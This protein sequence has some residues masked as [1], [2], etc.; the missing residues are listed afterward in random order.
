MSITLRDEIETAINRQSAESGSN[1]PDFILA[2]YLTD[3]LAAFDKACNA[4]GRWYGTEIHDQKVLN[5][6]IADLP[7]LPGRDLTKCPSCGG[8]A[9]NGHDREF[10]PNV[11]ACTK[12]SAK[13]G[14][15]IAYND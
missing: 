3:C 1:T 9:D 8:P 2:E 14:V 4:R 7:N 15:G 12:C 10:P 5:C 6:E 13:L 11:Y